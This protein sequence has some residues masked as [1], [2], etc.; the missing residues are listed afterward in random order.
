L[1]PHGAVFYDEN[2]AFV[3]KRVNA[4]SGDHKTRYSPVKVTL[5]LAY[6]DGWLV[7]GVD[8]DDE[9]VVQGAGTLW[10]LQGLGAIAVD[11]DQD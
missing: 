9:I 4:Q 1:L 6:G 11:D 10:S 8:N 7:D 3:Y 2:G 5:L